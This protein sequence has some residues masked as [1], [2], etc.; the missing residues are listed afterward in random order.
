MKMQKLRN[1]VRQNRSS[2]SGFSTRRS[3]AFGRR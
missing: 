2:L 1:R 3:R